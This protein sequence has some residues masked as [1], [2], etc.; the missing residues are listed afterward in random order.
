MP[1]TLADIAQRAD[2]SLST[3]SRVLN[4]KEHVSLG[5][6][7]AVLEA[8]TTLGYSRQDARREENLETVILFVHEGNG[9]GVNDGTMAQDAERQIVAGVQ[10]T[11]HAE[12]FHTQLA[13]KQFGKTRG[14]DLPR[15]TNLVGAI[16]IGSISNP[17]L[18]RKMVTDGVPTVIAGSPVPDMP[19]DS[20]TLDFKGAMLQI[21]EHLVARGHRVIGLVNGPEGAGSS[22]ARYHGL[23]LGLALHNL[24]FAPEQA[25]AANFTFSA[26]DA[27]T[28]TLL[29]DCPSVDA[30]IYGDDDI[31]VGGLRALRRMGRRVPD[32]IAVVGMFNYE[33]A[34]FT[35]PPLTTVDL[36]KHELGRAAAQRLLMRLRAKAN[37]PWTITL[38]TQLIVR[39]SA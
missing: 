28:H 35:E 17:H 33:I 9:E 16:N 8:V 38:P 15:V 34:T 7:T 1:I 32:D 4:N 12:G 13:H 39:E 31:A 27:M 21:I 24:P 22:I 36:D 20:V 19:L 18:L 14:F 23:R 37:Q 26:G 29:D 6:R 2:V 5:T 10:A 3:V 30:I 11:L 25:V